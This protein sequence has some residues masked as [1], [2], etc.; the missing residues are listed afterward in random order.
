MTT[1]IVY[2][3]ALLLII[4]GTFIFRT[5]IDAWAKQKIDG[6]NI[7]KCIQWIPGI[8]K[9]TSDPAKQTPQAPND[10][11]LKEETRK[12]EPDAQKDAVKQSGR[13]DFLEQSFIGLLLFWMGIIA[14]SLLWKIEVGE[15]A[16]I[17]PLFWAS[18]TAFVFHLATSWKIVN[19]NEIAVRMFLGRPKHNV[20]S[21]IVLEIWPV[22]K[23]KTFPRTRYQYLIK[24]IEDDDERTQEEEAQSDGEKRLRVIRI[25]TASKE[26]ARV[27]IQTMDDDDEYKSHFEKIIEAIK[28]IGDPLDSRLTVEPTF[29]I[30]FRILSPFY[31]IQAVKDADDAQKQ[32]AQAVISRAQIEFARLTPTLILHSLKYINQKLTEEVEFMIGEKPYADKDG[33]KILKDRWGIEIQDVYV[34]TFGITKSVN[35]QIAKQVTQEIERKIKKSEGIGLGERTK[36]RLLRETEGYREMGEALKEPGSLA[37]FQGEVA[38]NVAKSSKTSVMV[39]GGSNLGNAVLDIARAFKL[40]GNGPIDVSPKPKEDPP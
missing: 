2:S 9:E 1:I 13:K 38:Q 31:F 19:A 24:F 22:M 18:L 11:Q 37:A 25:T 8:K 34:K 12:E 32:I 16:T 17:R 15:E 3:V 28:D 10:D 35:E 4:T 6:W 29:V 36:Q 30:R 33:K 40:A 21:G 26:N 27:S 5:K 7:P 20:Q 39:G 14:L 23:V